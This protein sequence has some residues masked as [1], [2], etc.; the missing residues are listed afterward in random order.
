[1]FLEI[2]ARRHSFSRSTFGL[3]LGGQQ[4]I[5]PTSLNFLGTSPERPQQ[6]LYYLFCGKFPTFSDF[7]Q[8]LFF[9]QAQFSIGLAFGS[10]ADVL[11]SR[12]GCHGGVLSFVCQFSQPILIRFGDIPYSQT[13]KYRL[14]FK[15]VRGM[16]NLTNHTH[17]GFR[18]L[19]DF[20]D[21]PKNGM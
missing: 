4:P 12:D 21:T 11:L 2:R 7:H 5:C 18:V 13:R 10:S 20:L 15:S 16:V 1:M 6:S 14:N 9:W 17:R 19:H 8:D 3:L